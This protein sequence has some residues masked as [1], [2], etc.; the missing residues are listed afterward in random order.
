MH[1]ARIVMTVGAFLFSLSAC[2]RDTRAREDAAVAP[3]TAMI[4]D[5]REDGAPKV[6]RSEDVPGGLFELRGAPSTPWGRVMQGMDSARL[7]GGSTVVLTAG[8][9]RARPIELAHALAQAEPVIQESVR[10]DADGTTWLNG[11]K[12]ASPRDLHAMLARVGSGR[13][14]A[15]LVHER[16]PLAKVLD[17]VLAVEPIGLPLRFGNEVEPP[18]PMPEPLPAAR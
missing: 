5:V 7:K 2:R 14:I 11:A 18:V 4:V 16:A 17:V 15:L 10:L 9:R 8:D 12:V 6:T 1:S 3:R 13:K